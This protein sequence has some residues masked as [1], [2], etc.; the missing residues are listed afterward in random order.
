MFKKIV[1][2]FLLVMMLLGAFVVITNFIAPDL[3]GKFSVKTYYPEIPDCKDW[4][5]D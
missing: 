2:F 4:E 1:K 5:N 3:H